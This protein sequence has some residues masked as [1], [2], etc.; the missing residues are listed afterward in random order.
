MAQRE[1]VCI[2]CPKGCNLTVMIRENNEFD[3][4]GNTC[5]KG[6]EYAKK[7]LT[8]PRR[9]VTTTVKVKGGKYPMVSVK[10][11]SDIPKDKIMACIKA[12]SDIEV[13]A[14]V[15]IGDI[16]LKNAADTGVDVV[17]TKEVLA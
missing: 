14:P 7:E 8:D 10:T 16:I 1:L 5:N 4:T 11:A 9:I 12:L 2:G 17:A 15:R 3:I 13:E 6:I